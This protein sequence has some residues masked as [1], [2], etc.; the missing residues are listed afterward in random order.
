MQSDD[1]RRTRTQSRI[2]CN[3]VEV[4]F[5]YTGETEDKRGVATPC[6]EVVRKL[7]ER[8]FAV[9]RV[10]KN[11][12][13]DGSSFRKPV[14][15]AWNGVPASEKAI[16]VGHPFGLA[17][18]A[19][20]DCEVFSAADTTPFPAGAC[21]LPQHDGHDSY[22]QHDCETWP[23]NSGSPVLAQGAGTVVALHYCGEFGEKITPEQ[24]EA[25]KQGARPRNRS[26]PFS[27]LRADLKG[28]TPD[29]P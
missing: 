16:V 8:D 21:A 17:A 23:G 14:T 2:A 4:R 25:M 18:A 28:L 11:R 9:L 15:I 13:K 5:D 26:V 22:V 29:N 12:I 27:E 7:E 24:V 19:G 20:L 10:D 3:D 1:F 6:L